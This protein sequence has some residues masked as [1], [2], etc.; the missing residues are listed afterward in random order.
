MKI[1]PTLALDS[2]KADHRR[3]FPSGMSLMFSN[4]T[5]RK[6]YRRVPLSENGKTGIIFVGLQY[7][8][9]EYL[10]QQWNENFFNKPKEECV[11]AFWRTIDGHLPGNG[12]RTLPNGIDYDHIASLHDLGYLPLSIYALPEGSFVPYKVAPFVAWNTHPDFAWLTNYIE[13]ISSVTNWVMSTAATTIRVMRKV[14]DEYAKDT[15]NEA[16]VKFL[17]HNFS[18][19][20]CAGHE[21]ACMI[22]FG[23]LTSSVGSDTIPGIGFCEQYYNANCEKELISCSVPAT[24]HATMASHKQENEIDTFKYLIKTLYPSGFV[25]IVS[26]TWDYWKVIGEFTKVLK[27]DILARDG[28]VVF[29]PDSGDN[30]K[31]I[32]GD[33]SAPVDSI[34]R[35]GTIEALWDIFGGTVNTKGYKELNSHVGVILGDGVTLDVLMAICEGLKQKGFATTNMCFG[36][37]SYTYQYG[38]SRDTDGWAQKATFCTV[39]GEDREIFKDPKTDT[40]GLKKSAKGLIAVYQEDGNYIQKDQSSWDD[41]LNCCYEPVFVDGKLLREES[42]SQI[43]LRINPNF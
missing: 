11:K 37:G 10:I 36:V 7:F 16:L 39:N 19:R 35:K 13:T 25:S 31:I 30:V 9:K 12:M 40:G 1:N 15:G 22:D 23:H 3:Q 14:M 20:G 21:A 18:Y 29:R 41:V 28:K 5:P 2:Y 26:D 24:E 42:L 27:D 17:L 34:E 6:T 4:F 43:R 38:V 33:P 32:I 8:I